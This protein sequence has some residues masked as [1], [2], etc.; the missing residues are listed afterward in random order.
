MSTPATSPARKFYE[1]QIAM[2]Q[3]GRTDELI[4]KHY[5]ND[6]KLVSFQS[7]VRGREDLKRYFQSYVAKLGKLDVLSLDQF[8]ETEDSILFEATVRTA[9]GV[10][11]V[12][13]AFVL[14]DGRATHHFTGVK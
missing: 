10:V 5:A 1:E 13:D 3:P 9:L 2:L 12:Y 14:Q 8:A 4:D 11:K 7:I 6:A